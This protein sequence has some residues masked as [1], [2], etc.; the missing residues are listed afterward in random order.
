MRTLIIWLML[1]GV[2]LA[3]DYCC[4]DK[5]GIITEKHWSVD[6][7]DLR[8]RD[9]CLQLTHEEMQEVT[10]WHKIVKGALAK[11]TQEEID[12]IVAARA[13][14]AKQTAIDAV[15]AYQIDSEWLAKALVDQ[16]LISEADLLTAIKT[17]KGLTP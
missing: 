11:M 12:A 5:D 9:D 8:A 2:A 6:G 4:F 14:A 15:D 7:A 10:E 17:L 13:A 1:C 16:N 3:G